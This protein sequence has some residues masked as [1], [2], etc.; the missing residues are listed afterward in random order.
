[1]RHAFFGDIHANLEALKAVLADMITQ[2]I[3]DMY[4]LG[5]IVGYGANPS[6]CIAIIRDLACPT[7]GGNHDAAAAGKLAVDQF[8]EY[9]RAAII[10]T[11]RHLSQEETDWLL[12]L[13]LIRHF[14]DY[15]IVHSSL[16]D[17]GDF[18]YVDS[19]VEAAACFRK[20]QRPLCFIGHS[21]VPVVFFE[22]EPQALPRYT[23]S[24]DQ[25]I[26][27]EGRMIVNPGSVGQPR[28]ED[29]RAAYC[30]YDSDEMQITFRRVGYDTAAA[31]GKVRA[32]GLPELLAFR[33]EIGR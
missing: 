20:M 7:V 22:D 28:D 11:R 8:N 32:A 31:A 33:L 30:I 21:H 3:D 23:L 18:N 26:Q 5:D 12:A 6:E 4:C 13:P 14:P 27:I 25:T 9:A 15:S 29:P 2:R 17:P 10:W 16:D 24:L 1:M 19:V